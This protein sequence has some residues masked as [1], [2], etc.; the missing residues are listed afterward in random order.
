MQTKK[1]KN[2]KVLFGLR[3]PTLFGVNNQDATIDCTDTRKHVAQK[4]NVSRHIDE[5]RRCTRWQTGVSETEVD[6]HAAALLFCPP[7]RVG[8]S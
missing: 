6:C 8:A 7:I 3:H 4:A 1:F 2:L 5:T